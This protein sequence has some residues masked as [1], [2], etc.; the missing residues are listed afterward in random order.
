M[1]GR[2]ILLSSACCVALLAGCVP[3][4]DVPAESGRKGTFASPSL[5]QLL[6]SGDTSATMDAL[7]SGIAARKAAE[8]A[9][10]RAI[11]V[12]RAKKARA[13]ALAKSEARAAGLAARSTGTR[14][15]VAPKSTWHEPTEAEKA[16]AARAHA[17]E[18]AKENMPVIYP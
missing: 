15:Y 1:R 5:S 2:L 13:E 6:P 3:A 9:K 8:A 18:H 14:K 12:A 4:S 7:V 17:L 11:A 16:A 10:V